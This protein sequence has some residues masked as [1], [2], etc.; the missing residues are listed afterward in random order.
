MA[1]DIVSEIKRDY[2]HALIRGGKRYDGRAFDE[3]RPVRIEPRVVGQAEGSCRVRI[4]DTEVI[5]GVKVQPG[6]PYPD[7][8]ASGVMMTSAELIP[9][10]APDFEAGPPRGPA[11]EL[12]RVV[13]RGIRETET[14]DMDKL[15]IT[16][17][18][19]VWMCFIDIHVID[20]DGN[21]FDAS[22]LAAMAALLTAKVPAKRYGKGEDF[23]L[24]VRHTPISVTAVKV[25]GGIVFDPSLI[26]DK[27]GSPRLTVATDENGLIR[28]MQKGMAGGFTKEEVVSVIKTARVKGNDLREQLMIAV[29]S[30]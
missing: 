23:P 22:S 11:I 21:L 24:P 29:G 28:A 30:K 15:C 26:E 7:Q 27:V 5:V 9:M 3:F 1:Q 12:A 19:A 14:I 25:G 13:D 2:V 18:E 20:Y 16:P 6:T 17:E 8:P 10:A 4:G